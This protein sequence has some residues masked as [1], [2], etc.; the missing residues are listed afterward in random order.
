MV[1]GKIRYLVE[2]DLA[3]LLR[4]HQTLAVVATNSIT[5]SRYPHP[6]THLV[7]NFVPRWKFYIHEI[8]IADYQLTLLE[9]T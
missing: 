7:V 3:F 5:F 9:S 1:S 8:R 2:V 4:V 6:P